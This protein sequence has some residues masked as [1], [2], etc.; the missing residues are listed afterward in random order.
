MGCTRNDTRESSE[1]LKTITTSVKLKIS[2]YKT[3]RDA[4]VKNAQMY[5]N[6]LE[7]IAITKEI[8]NKKSIFIWTIT[9]NKTNPQKKLYEQLVNSSL[10]I[11]QQYQRWL[12]IK[13]DHKDNVQQAKSSITAGTNQLD[14]TISYL[15]E[16]SSKPKF[17]EEAKFYIDFFHSVHSNV[18]ALEDEAIEKQ[19]EI[20]EKNK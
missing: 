13:N 11:E 1:W 19:K 2:N 14:Q 17:K 12:K 7:K 6:S 15:S 9:N 3:R 4:I 10:K 5:T 16:L 8:E 20:F 18:S